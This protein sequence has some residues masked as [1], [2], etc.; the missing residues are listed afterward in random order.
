[1]LRLESPQ[2]PDEAVVVLVGDDRL[3]AR[4]IGPLGRRHEGGYLV[5]TLPGVAEVLSH[6]TIV[7]HLT[8]RG[9]LILAKG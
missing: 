9:S 2:F 8:A 6:L 3:V 1:M 7:A 4:M 5:P